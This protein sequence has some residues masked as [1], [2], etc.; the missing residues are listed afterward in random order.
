MYVQ[1]EIDMLI[2]PSDQLQFWWFDGTW[3]GLVVPSTGIWYVYVPNTAQL[4]SFDFL[5]GS[6]GSTS[7]QYVHIDYIYID[8]MSTM[9]PIGLNKFKCKN[10]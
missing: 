9:L 1:F 4:F 2:R 8:C 5:T 10:Q 3:N 7:L 6:I